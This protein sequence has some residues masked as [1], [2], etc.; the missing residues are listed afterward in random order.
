M[1]LRRIFDKLLSSG[2]GRRPG[3]K[4]PRYD[5]VRVI[6]MADGTIIT[7][8]DAVAAHFE[9]EQELLEAYGPNIIFQVHRIKLQAPTIDQLAGERVAEFT[10]DGDFVCGT[11]TVA[12]VEAN[13]PS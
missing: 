5:N 6:G 13:E 3:D 8:Q 7:G 1:S 10:V 12:A 9:R 4:Q 11:D 2:S